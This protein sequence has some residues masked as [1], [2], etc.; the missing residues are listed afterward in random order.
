MLLMPKEMINGLTTAMKTPQAISIRF[1]VPESDA[2]DRL[3]ELA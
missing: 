1:E 2:K 3:L